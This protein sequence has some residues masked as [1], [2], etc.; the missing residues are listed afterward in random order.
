M[1]LEKIEALVTQTILVTPARQ[2]FYRG[3]LGR[4]TGLDNRRFAIFGEN[5]FYLGDL[6]GGRLEGVNCLC[7]RRQK[8]V[9]L[10]LVFRR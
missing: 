1:L 5:S 10:L 4:Q 9:G 6:R 7:R 8:Q 3:R 2:G